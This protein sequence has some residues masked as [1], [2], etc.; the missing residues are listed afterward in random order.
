MSDRPFLKWPGGKS[1]LGHFLLPHIDSGQGLV[2][3]FVGSASAYLA[4]GY[5]KALLA[6]ANPDLI[7]VYSHLKADPGAFVSDLERLF[8]TKNNT[9]S[10]Y[11]GL[12]DRFNR[13]RDSRKRALLFVYLNRHGYRGLI[14]YNQSGGF[15]V[16]YGHYRKPAL[17]TERLLKAAQRLEQCA[18][19]CQSYQDTMRLAKPGDV[20]Y[21]DPPYSPL[22]GRNSF[23]EYS[24]GGFQHSDHLELARLALEASQTGIKVVI[25][26]HD[27]E[28]TRALYQAAD[29]VEQFDVAR[30]IGSHH[31]E[32]SVRELLAIYLPK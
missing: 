20:I 3:P 19:L 5:D 25:S 23:T 1:R 13:C 10:A 11:Y 6:D 31:A 9:E 7:A 2:E 21:C 30:A 16:P 14:R 4:S 15:N 22:P 8:T 26:N 12:R 29:H 24:T 18:I 17:P 28:S 27:T 32:K